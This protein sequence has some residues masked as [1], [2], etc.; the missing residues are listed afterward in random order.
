MSMNIVEAFIKFKGQ[1]IILISGMSGSGI[2]KLAKNISKDFKIQFL[3]SSNFMKTE[4]VDTIKLMDGTEIFNWDTDDLIDFETLNKKISEY[5]KN[6]VVVCGQSFPNEKLDKNNI[7]D[8]HIHVKLNKQNLLMKRHKYIEKHKDDYPE[9]YER[10]NTSAEQL[11]FNKYTFPYY[12]STIENSTIHKFINA[13]DFANLPIKEY[14]EKLYDEA[15]SYLMNLIAKWLD[16]Y[17]N[18]LISGTIKPKG[19]KEN[20]IEMNKNIIKDTYH[21]NYDNDNNDNDKSKN[22]NN[23]KKKNN[24]NDNDDDTDDST[25]TN[26]TLSSSTIDLDK[27]PIS[28]SDPDI[29][30]DY[31]L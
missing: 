10:L 28:L 19:Y 12:L 2:T 3:K 26:E 25:I 21:A 1:L 31:E 20:E 6:G 22:K 30:D 18:A 15:F 14:N 24:D 17:N 5:K 16:N 8:T 7:I 27:E 9:L 23:E 11:I 4:G 13:N 29:Y